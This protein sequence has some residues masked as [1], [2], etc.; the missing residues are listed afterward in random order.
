MND[1]LL[2]EIESK[3]ELDILKD[4]IFVDKR[5]VYFIVNLNINPSVCNI[6]SGDLSKIGLPVFESIQTRQ[7]LDFVEPNNLLAEVEGKHTFIESIKA[8]FKTFKDEIFLYIPIK[9]TNQPIWL[10]VSFRKLQTKNIVL[11]Q[12]VRVYEDTPV[13]IIHY[14]KT[15]QDS[16]TR[17]FS[18]ETLKMHMSYLQNTKGSYLLYLDIDGFKAI[19]DKYGHQ[20]GDQF[21]IDIANFF[22]SKWEYNV[23][24]YRLGGDEFAMYCY[25]HDDAS[26]IKRTKA[27]IHDIENL[28]DIA[29]ELGVSVS[30]GIVKISKKHKDYH[31]LLNLGDKMMYVSKEKG[32]G[33]FT[34]FA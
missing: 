15:Y 24:Y 34:I 31:Q 6:I 28:N 4:L 18:R 7:L 19:N 8:Q 1:N 12:V 5:Q 26:I 30:V 33:K 32:K 13:N 16:L 21:L 25:D 14:Q 2:K 3:F 11:G 10:Y 23:L 20:A 17:L 27:L 22:I 9:S 29:K